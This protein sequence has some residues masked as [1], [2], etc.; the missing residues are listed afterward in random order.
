M[1]W[2]WAY[3]LRI[4][5]WLLR[6]WQGTNIN[7]VYTR[8]VLIPLEDFIERDDPAVQWPKIIEWR[9]LLKRGTPNQLQSF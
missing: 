6:L 1:S 4:G 3:C 2:I 9:T 5:Y 8:Y 7:K